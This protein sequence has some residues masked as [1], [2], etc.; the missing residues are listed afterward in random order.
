M[1]YFIFE[2]HIP[3]K[4]IIPF[5]LNYVNVPLLKN[6]GLTWH[7]NIELIFCIEGNGKIICDTIQYEISKGDL[8][9]ITPHLIHALASDSRIKYYCIT[10]NNNFCKENGIIFK[11][12]LSHIFSN[13]INYDNLNKIV[14]LHEKNY[15]E[16]APELRH[17]L[18]GMLI[19]IYR[20][21]EPEKQY[22]AIDNIN[23]SNYIKKAIK[24]IEEHY[25]KPLSVDL[26]AAELAISRSH[27][28]HQFKLFTHCTIIDYLNSVRCNKAKFLIKSGMNVSEAAFTVGFNNLS[29]FTRV[30]KKHMLIL[31]SQE[32]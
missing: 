23:Q 27:L 8:A 3:S 5:T 30:Y 16:Y 15:K 25:S 29:Y 14:D 19:K 2:N 7:D 4:S 18:L 13:F 21:L 32:R 9:I 1:S 6:S 10:V 20:N 12:K 26:I 22:S 24:Y 17:L 28:E 11:D 31:P